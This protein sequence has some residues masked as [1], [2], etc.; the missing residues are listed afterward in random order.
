MTKCIA[1]HSYKGGTGKSTISSNLSATLARKGL[2]AVLLDLDVYAPSLQDYFQW[3]PHKSI[4]DYLFE[5][6][7]VDEVI[8]DL[9]AVL[10]K[11]PSKNGEQ[12]DSKGKLLV[13]FSSTSKDEIY[14]LDGAVRQEGSKIQLLRKFLMLR[15]EIVSKYNADFIIIDTSPGIRY[16]SINSL[17]I[18]DT[19]L[20]SLKLDG[21]D[22][23]GTRLLAKEIYDS[24]TKLGTKSYLLLNRAAGYC[25]PPNLSGENNSSNQELYKTTVDN[26]T[27]V[28]SKLSAD[29]GMDTI[30]SIPCYCDIQFDSNE[31]LTALRYP[32]HPFA[33]KIESL[34]E[35]LKK[36]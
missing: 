23:K 20:L 18:A 3:Q 10:K 14:K 19:I 11:F 7:T 25:L 8:H 16:W 1:L 12:S 26:Q 36:I 17:A 29:V 34:I 9:S 6:A 30:L 22:L 2:T 32:D 31:F 27:T 15:E 35:Q 5:N 24:L 4:N 33:G 28:I 21:I 13:A